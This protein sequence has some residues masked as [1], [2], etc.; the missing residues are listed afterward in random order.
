MFPLKISSAIALLMPI[1]NLFAIEIQDLA[2]TTNSVISS[3]IFAEK[4]NTD[5]PFSCNSGLEYIPLPAFSVPNYSS[6]QIESDG[7]IKRITQNWPTDTRQINK[8]LPNIATQVVVTTIGASA[9]AGGLFS[10]SIHHKQITIDFMKYRSEPITDTEGKA[11]IY[12]RVGAGMRLQIQISTSEANLGGSLLAI[13]ASASA[14]KTAGTISTDIIGIDAN[15]VT[16]SMP[17]TS[18][19]SEGSIQKIIEALAI[20]KSRLNDTS[21]TL[22]PQF[23]A[24]IQCIQPKLNTTNK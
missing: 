19:L 22:A 4:G 6:I 14:G 5:S 21:T 24:K 16:V 3:G 12:S 20:V 23:I 17:F 7:K 18:D 8:L 15:D 9:N 11:N 13:A 2:N 1:H 10:T